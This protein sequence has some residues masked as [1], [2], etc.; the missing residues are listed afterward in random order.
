MGK[1]KSKT[2]KKKQAKAAGGAGGSNSRKHKT[3][4]TKFGGVTVMKGT[5]GFS[6]T[7]KRSRQLRVDTKN[8]PPITTNN[9][10]STLRIPQIRRRQGRQQDLCSTLP[11]TTDQEQVD[12]ED[13]YAS[14]RERQRHSNNVI[15]SSKKN[16]TNKNKSMDK[17]LKREIKFAPSILQ[18]STEGNQSKSTEDLVMD[19]TYRL[20]SGSIN[21]REGGEGLFRPEPQQ[22]AIYEQNQQQQQQQQQPSAPPSNLLQTMATKIRRDERLQLL[23]ETSTTTNTNNK[24]VAK[25]NKFWAL[26]EDGSDEEGASMLTNRFQF[27]PASFSVKPPPLAG[28]TSILACGVDQDDPDL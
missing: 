27:T 22:W 18:P 20:S 8:K 15:L 11:K 1:K 19:A 4:A 10:T 13:E 17:S 3:G 6:S 25:N 26:Q 5:G 23:A 14:L 28:R 9:N 21:I 16:K 12:F 7:L 2:S 24:P